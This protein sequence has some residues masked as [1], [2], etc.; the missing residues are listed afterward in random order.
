M[1]T[2]AQPSLKDWAF[3]DLEN[4]ITSTRRVLE[5]VPDEHM[6]WKPHPKSFTLGELATHVANLLHWQV[7]TLTGDGFDL[8]GG[9]RVAAAENR[10]ELLRMFDENR[11]ALKAAFDAADD[12]S[13]GTP[14]TLRSGD[15]VVFTMPRR[16]VLRFAGI[17]HLVHHRAQLTVY[18]RLLDVPLPG[19][20]GPTADETNPPS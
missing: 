20:Y 19:L 8:A 14:W 9:P 17:S 6:G 7:I 2:L 1:S 5:R 3:A 11:V 18:L 13:L 4:E 15:H 10:E 12:D 16:Q